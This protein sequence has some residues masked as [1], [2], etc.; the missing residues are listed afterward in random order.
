MSAPAPPSDNPQRPGEKQSSQMLKQTIALMLGC[1]A[2]DHDQQ[3]MDVGLNS[4]LAVQLR[5]NLATQLSITMPST[6]SFDYPTIAEIATF[7]DSLS[8][9]APLS[10]SPPPSH[11]SPM[12][13]PL[14]KPIGGTGL[15]CKYPL[16]ASSL[17]S[18]YDELKS[19]T[20]RTTKI[21]L[22][23]WDVEYY[24]DEQAD[25]CFHGAFI[26]GVQHFAPLFF[27]I[28]KADALGMDPQQRMVLEVGYTAL[29]RAGLHKTT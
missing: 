12:P 13:L 11:G 26:E 27:G 8:A 1:D 15:A 6:L 21:P 17:H 5:Q 20:S 19:G 4:M 7:L 18:V 2:I 14:K 28:S 24:V 25:V 22:T 29:N 9:P 3:L 16:G 10:N 23:R